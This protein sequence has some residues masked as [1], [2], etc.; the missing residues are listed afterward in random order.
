MRIIKRCATLSTAIMFI[1]SIVHAAPEAENSL[2][3]DDWGDELTFNA[4]NYVALSV[5]G[6]NQSNQFF[7]ALLQMPVDEYLLLDAGAGKNMISDTQSSFTTKSFQFGISSVQPAGLN[8]H[9]GT[10]FWGKKQVIETYDLSFE[11]SY[12]SHSQWHTSV[13]LEHGT[14]TLFIKPFFSSRLTSIGSDRSAW[15]INTGHANDTGNWWLSYMKREYERNL[16]ALDNDRTLQIIV[17]NNALD[18]AYALSSD[19][20]A[21]GYEWYFQ[22]SDFSIQFNRVTSVVD[23]SDS[24]Y[25]IMAHRY[26]ASESIS[27]QTDLQSSLNETLMSLSVGLGIL[28]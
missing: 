8:M 12:Q 9:V 11:L 27:V 3:N 2:L 24:D 7:D 6:D 10:R 19:E 18:L 22:Q 21:L 25:L 5:G 16:P 13:Q 17:Q 28:W 14:V 23:N 1:A 4:S 20:Y 26:Y 15:G